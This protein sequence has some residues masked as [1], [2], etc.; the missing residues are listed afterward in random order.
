MNRDYEDM[1]A[2]ANEGWVAL[3][4]FALLV[5]A[6]VHVGLMLK[7]SDCAFAPLPGSGGWK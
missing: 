3:F 5:S 7:L 1:S 6:A 2:G 4:I